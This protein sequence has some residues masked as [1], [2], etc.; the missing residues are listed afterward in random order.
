MRDGHADDAF[1]KGGVVMT[2]EHFAFNLVP[3]SAYIRERDGLS[4]HVLDMHAVCSSSAVCKTFQSH[5]GNTLWSGWF[6]RDNSYRCLHT[7]SPR[8]S[9][10]Q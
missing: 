1:F 2:D 8:H 9:G 10:V 6:I 4:F 5:E 3:D 7:V